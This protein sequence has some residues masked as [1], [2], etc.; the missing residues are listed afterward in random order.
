MATCESQCRDTGTD[1]PYS[2]TSPRRL[3][4]HSA[5]CPTS[6]SA[7]NS[8]SIVDRAIQ[9]YLADFHEI[10]PPP[11]INTHPV[12][13]FTSSL[14]DTQLASQYPSNTAGKLLKC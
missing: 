1:A 7:I 5:S 9:V 11:S 2:G 3:F 8:Y 12:V 13:E 6:L 4:S 10:T 14:S